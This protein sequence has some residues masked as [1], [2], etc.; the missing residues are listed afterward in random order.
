MQDLPLPYQHHPQQAI[1]LVLLLLFLGTRCRLDN[2]EADI[3]TYVHLKDV[4]LQTNL[5]T[6]GSASSNITEAWWFIDDQFYGAFGFPSTVPIPVSPG[7]TLRLE[8][9][10]RDNGVS[11]TPD[12]YPFYEPISVNPLWIPESI[13]TLQAI[14]RYRSNA[15]FPLIENYETGLTVFQR[16]IT[17]N[18]SNRLRPAREAA[19]E[20]DFG[21]LIELTSDAPAAELAS[22]RRFRG[23]QDSGI[24][25]YLEMDFRSEAPVQFGVVAYKA[26][27]DIPLEITYVAGFNPSDTWKK[28]YF[29]LSTAIANSEGEEFELILQTTLPT[30]TDG[31][32]TRNSAKIRMDNLKLVHFE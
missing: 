9:G 4:Q 31:T 6:E 23:L 25:V 2:L 22:I 12:L 28:I 18:A 14:F 30:Q 15:A 17:G 19:F 3:P 21:G 24:P 10:I 16:V 27:S 11:S 5:A 20:G 29:N 32:L 7:S 26:G 8:A 1:I 13:D